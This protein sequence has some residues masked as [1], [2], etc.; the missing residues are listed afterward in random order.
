MSLDNSLQGLKI[1]IETSL[2]RSTEAGINSV[3]WEQVINDLSIDLSKNINAYAISARV[4]TE[5]LV[6]PGALA[7]QSAGVTLAPVQGSGVGTISNLDE[8]NLK[9]DIE[10]AY[11][12]AVT[13]STET[14]V[15]YV[16]INRNLGEDVSK[17]IYRYAITAKVLTDNELTAF[18][19][20]GLPPVAITPATFPAGET[21]SGEGENG[22]FI[23]KVQDGEFK[24]ENLSNEIIQPNAL[25][26]SRFSLN[27]A[28]SSFSS[29]L[30]QLSLEV[31]IFIV[32]KLSSDK[33]RLV[34][35]LDLDGLMFNDLEVSEIIN[36]SASLSLPDAA[37]PEDLGLT[38]LGSG[39]EGLSSKIS[40]AYNKAVEDGSL[41]GANYK[42]V[43]KDLGESIGQAVHDFFKSSVVITE[44]IYDGGLV[45]NP[46][47]SQMPGPNGLIPTVPTPQTLPG[48]IGGGIGRLI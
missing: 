12:K 48:A 3:E 43:N 47:S 41:T 24:I 30:R 8:K 38:N 18:D 13:R 11:T 10:R 27:T 31:S 36:S 39:I 46:L 20:S 42:N 45:E 32:Q 26:V 33:L 9:I 28:L 19:T 21:G 25:G 7:T 23:I 44:I 6:A 29:S 1:D 37:A 40:A 15:S 2:N 17:S 16:D 5:D 35:A 34:A 22:V 4:E 14:G